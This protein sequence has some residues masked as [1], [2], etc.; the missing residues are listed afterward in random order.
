MAQTVAQHP[1][2]AFTS[3]VNNTTPIDANA[4]R[5]NDNTLRG[6]YVD[7]DADPGIHLQSSALASRPA[8]GSLG[9]KWLTAD[10]GS[11]RLFFDDGA[12]WYELSYLSS[13]G[14]TLT[15]VLVLP[16]GMVSA[17]SVTTTGDLNTGLWFPAADTVSITAGGTE[18]F[19]VNDKRYVR[20]STDAAVLGSATDTHFITNSAAGQAVLNFQHRGGSTPNGISVAFTAAAPNN[21]TEF[22]ATFLDNAAT[23]ATVYSDGTIQNTGIYGRLD[24]TNT[25]LQF[26]GTDIVGMLTGGTERWR[27]TAAGY[28]KASNTGTYVGATQNYHELN[29]DNTGHAVNITN[30]SATTPNGLEINFTGTTPNNTTQYF[31]RCYDLTSPFTR[32]YIFSNGDLQ[33]ANGVYGTISDAKLKQDVVDAGSQWDDLKA[34]RFRKYRFK[35]DV[36]EKG[37]AAPYLLGVVAQELREVSPGLVEATPDTER[38][39]VVGDDGEVSVEYRPTGTETLSVKQSVLLMKAAKA[40]QEAMER[41]EVLE[42]RLQ[43]AGVP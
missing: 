2:S 12:N 39:E 33:N 11:Y 35:S 5:G 31:L 8:A 7:H 40:L 34:I 36:T 23:R 42:A 29:S 41:I 14:G 1:V 37:D 24:D 15:G 9:R 27:T 43:A 10:S 19:R 28:L 18:A 32:A 30:S 20:I 13:A 4:V 22:F 38:V 16:A 26:L 21:Q 25:Y 17:P 3:P 6:A